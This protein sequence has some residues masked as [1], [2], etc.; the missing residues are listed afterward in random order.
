MLFRSRFMDI[1]LH[2]AITCTK[3]G[4]HP[5]G[6]LIVRGSKVISKS[7]N[8]THRDA[9][10]THH[11]EIVAIGRASKKLGKNNL[12]NCVLYTTHEPCPMCAAASVYAKLGGVV[13]GTSIHDAIR[14]A[15]QNPQVIWRSID[16]PLSMMSDRAKNTQLVIVEGFMKEQ[17]ALLFNLLLPSVKYRESLQKKS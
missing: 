15:A 10:P 13:F 11:A 5:V 3:F 7:G 8:R 4:E 16:I 9:N 1:A 14:F 17:C 12:S 2:E 6:A